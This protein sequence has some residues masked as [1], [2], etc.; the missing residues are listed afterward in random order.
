MI[1]VFGVMGDKNYRMMAK[2]LFPLAASVIVTRPP[3]GRALPPQELIPV[4]SEFNGSI[5]VIEDPSEALNRA[6]LLAGEDDLICVAGSLY[7]VGEI[8]KIHAKRQA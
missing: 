3:Y 8:K 7:L 2:R 4:A 5:E 1:L 6:F